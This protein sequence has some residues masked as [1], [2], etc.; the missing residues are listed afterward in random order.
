MSYTIGKQ[1][2][3]LN[4]NNGTDSSGKQRTVSI[5]LADMSEANFSPSQTASQNAVIAIATALETCLDKAVYSIEAV[6]T[7]SISPNT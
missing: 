7:A 4:L 6:T 3:R 5:N 2:V 1:A